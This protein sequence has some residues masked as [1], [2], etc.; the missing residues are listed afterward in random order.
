MLL[1]GKNVMNVSIGVA[2][3]VLLPLPASALLFSLPVVFSLFPKGKP[4][5]NCQFSG[6]L[7]TRCWGS[8]KNKKYWKKM[9]CINLQLHRGTA[10]HFNSIHTVSNTVQRLSMGRC[11]STQNTKN[12]RKLLQVCKL[13][14]LKQAKHWTSFWL[15][16][17]SPKAHSSFGGGGQGSGI[18]GIP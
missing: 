8:N 9:S 15:P 17:M 7:G 6:H 5:Q 4:S 2:M 16:L 10:V 1:Q 12:P 18:A 3:F 11:R 13:K 14:K